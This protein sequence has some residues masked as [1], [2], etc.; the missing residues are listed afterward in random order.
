M[1][2]DVPEPLV[3]T[4]TH[5]DLPGLAAL[6]R[7]GRCP[8]VRRE[9][10]VIALLQRVGRLI[11]NVSA[12]DPSHTGHRKQQRYI[13]VLAC[14]GMFLAERRHSIQQ[15]SEPI[16]DCLLLVEEQTQLRK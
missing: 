5:H 2:H 12:D 7:H 9:R 15:V 3:A 11:D 14:L 8:A 10:M 1:V 16:A 13:A 6:F 4:K